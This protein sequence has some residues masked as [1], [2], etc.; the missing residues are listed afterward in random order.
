MI[1]IFCGGFFCIENKTNVKIYAIENSECRTNLNV[2]LNQENEGI[3][4]TKVQKMFL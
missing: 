1:Y 2:I 3:G 4:A